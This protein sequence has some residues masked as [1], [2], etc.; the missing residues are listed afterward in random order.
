VYPVAREVIA[1]SALMA[2]RH[3][4][5]LKLLFETFP[6]NEI[7]VNGPI[8]KK[9]LSYPNFFRESKHLKY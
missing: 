5:R 1:W 3:R 8:T 7:Q 4:A 9:N 6:L 2:I